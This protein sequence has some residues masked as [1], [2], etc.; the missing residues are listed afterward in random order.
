V[1][2][3]L[4]GWDTHA[5]NHNRTQTLC[6]V[7]DPAFSALIDDLATRGMLEETLVVCMGEFGRTPRINV[8][9][10]R[11]HWPNN[12]C[13][14]FAGGGVRATTI[15][16]ETD[17]L[18]MQIVNRPVQVADLFATIAALLG[19]DG[20]KEFNQSRRPVTLMDPNGAVVSELLT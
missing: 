8:R 13:V 18:G 14:T 15:V 1:E 9:D 2:V 3:V 20:S 11:D 6:R 19:I 12:Y 7:L 16:G 5:D 10:G 4:D 17:E